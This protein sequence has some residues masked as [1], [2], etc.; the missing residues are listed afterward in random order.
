MLRP[1]ISIATLGG[2]LSMQRC[3]PGG[4]ITPTL[5]GQALLATAPELNELADIKV[6]SL[7]LLPSASLD[8]AFLLEVVS[9]AKRQIAQGARGV[10]IT[11]GTDT[12]EETATFFDCLWDHHQPLVVTGAMRGAGQAGA[13]GPA[14]MLDACR[15]AIDDSSRKR[16]VLVV[17]NAEVH[18]A[19]SVRK[20]H[21]LALQA[22]SSPNVGPIGLVI[23]NSIHYL[24]AAAARK[25]LPWPARTTHKVALLEAVL[26]A[27]T[28]L[29]EHLVALGY[30]GLVI[31]GFGAGH[32]SEQWS[33]ALEKVAAKLPVIVS[34]RSGA[35]PTARKTYGFMGGE[36]D[37]VSKGVHLS[38]FLCPRKA[39]VLLW[40]LIGCDHSY[41]LATYLKRYGY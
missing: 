1:K 41:R 38:G 16:G 17:L 19:L 32:V 3:Q 35:G 14:N 13:D 23:E 27:D 6:E 39:R 8:F 34:T 33:K 2:T 40:L 36:I 15:V 12:L 21:S 24:R 37:L 20:T 10:V 29:L 4:G 11:Q 22:F 30:E 26:S 18:Q 5:A 7:S 25:V 9:W 28:V 31:A